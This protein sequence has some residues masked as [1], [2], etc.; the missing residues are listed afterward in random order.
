MEVIEAFPGLDELASEDVDI[1]F[2][3]KMDFTGALLKAVAGIK[4]ESPP[5][6]LNVHR[7]FKSTETNA[8]WIAKG[9]MIFCKN[10]SDHN[11]VD[12]SD[13]WETA[14]ELNACADIEE[15]DFNRFMQQSKGNLPPCFV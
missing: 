2:F 9:H 7:Y 13:A 10:P 5:V 8:I 1:A 3:A 14:D 4:D 11:W 15:I 6:L 12:V